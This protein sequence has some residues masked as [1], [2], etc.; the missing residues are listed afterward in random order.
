MKSFTTLL[1]ALSIYECLGGGAVLFESI[2]DHDEEKCL[3]LSP[4]Q[5]LT[6]N[7]DSC[8]SYYHNEDLNVDN[9]FEFD[10]DMDAILKIRADYE[11]DVQ[12]FLASGKSTDD[13][14]LTT[15][16]DANRKVWDNQND[17]NKKRSDMKWYS[18]QNK[19][20]FDKYMAHVQ[21]LGL[22]ELVKG[23]FVDG[24]VNVFNILFLVRSH[25]DVHHFHLDWSEELG[26]VPLSIV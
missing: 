25:S 18:P 4:S 22:Q 11:A 9:V 24:D 7:Y 14:C 26:Y 13:W 6:T 3:H 16:Y 2:N 10:L 19:E 1:L 15:P 20:T 12:P 8:V 21:R 5:N 23:K 17:H